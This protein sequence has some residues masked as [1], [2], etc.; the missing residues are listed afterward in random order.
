M[1]I[2]RRNPQAAISECR[3]TERPI[4]YYEA[5][6]SFAPE[7]GRR[8][9]DIGCGSGRLALRLAERSHFVVGL[10]RSPSMLEIA[11]NRQSG[12]RIANV[13][14]VLADAAALPFAD[15]AFDYVTSALALRLT[16]LEFSLPSLRRVVKVEGRAAVKELVREQRSYHP[17]SQLL[18]S[19][20]LLPALRKLYGLLAAF[21]LVVYMNL[22]ERFGGSKPKGAVTR[23]FFER[24]YLP[25][26]PSCIILAEKDASTLLWE[27]ARSNGAVPGMDL[28]GAGNLPSGT[29]GRSEDSKS[30]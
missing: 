20:S 12:A 9:L 6:L 8:T 7:N 5:I 16:N 29:A 30:A 26:F 25:F 27:K 1:D 28:A 17:G 13:A 24:T 22:P 14:W 11:Q 23:Q 3:A 19:L 21:K 10:D 18:H 15:D 2:V 4:Q